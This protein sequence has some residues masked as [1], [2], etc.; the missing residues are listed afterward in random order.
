MEQHMH[1]YFNDQVSYMGK[2]IV[3]VLHIQKKKKIKE[4][5]YQKDLKPLF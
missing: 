5:K 1:C 2:V 4:K 3:S